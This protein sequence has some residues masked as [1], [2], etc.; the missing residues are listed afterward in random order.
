MNLC[1]NQEF[2]KIQ[3]NYYE[4]KKILY[5]LISSMIIFEDD[6]YLT[7]EDIPKF[8]NFHNIID[9]SYIFRQYYLLHQTYMLDTAYHIIEKSMITDDDLR[10]NSVLPSHVK[11]SNRVDMLDEDLFMYMKA[12]I[13]IKLNDEPHKH[14][15]LFDLLM[16]ISEYHTQYLCGNMK[17]IVNSIEFEETFHQLSI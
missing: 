10:C 12:Y 7:H 16:D 15:E 4:I 17:E 5:T 9:L 1:N 11:G 13:F 8:L 14:E 2:Q 3:R 6:F